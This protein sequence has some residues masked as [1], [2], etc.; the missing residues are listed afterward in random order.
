M[1]EAERK[2]ESIKN[3]DIPQLGI[4]EITSK[5]ISIVIEN[6]K[7]N[8]RSHR[9]KFTDD[10]KIKNLEGIKDEK[11]K[12]GRERSY[13]KKKSSKNFATSGIINQY[14]PKKVKSGNIVLNTKL[15]KLNMN[16]INDIEDNHQLQTLPTTSQ[17]NI[18]EI[19][20]EKTET[21]LD[22]NEL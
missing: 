12:E 15:P 14:L 8:P 21:N 10:T 7:K 22:N 5:V 3:V 20:I 11:E 18:N 19:I 2:I 6:E 16:K 1:Q 4:N 17:K 9:A 13:S